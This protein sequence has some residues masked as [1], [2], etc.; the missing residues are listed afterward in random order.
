MGRLDMGASQ[1][2][3]LEKPVD[4]GEKQPMIH[5]VDPLRREY[6][7]CGK[8]LKKFVGI[9]PEVECVVCDDLKKSRKK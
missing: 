4:S 3:V 8:K 1:S 5:W 6:S 2:S 9:V 7:L